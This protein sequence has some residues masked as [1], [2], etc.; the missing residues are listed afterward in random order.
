MKNLE[1]SKRVPGPTRR[2]AQNGT[3]K[4]PGGRSLPA[5]ARSLRAK[6]LGR[7][8]LENRRPTWLS[9]GPG[10]SR[11]QEATYRRPGVA[12]GVGETRIRKTRDHD[13]NAARFAARRRIG[14]GDQTPLWIDPLGAVS[15]TLELFISFTPSRPLASRRG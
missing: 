12:Q 2:R 10:L 4:R 8:A 14:P 9:W 7:V 5:T 6:K 15:F 3:K 1:P 11:S 13:G